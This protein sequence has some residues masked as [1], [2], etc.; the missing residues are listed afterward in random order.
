MLLIS[1]TETGEAVLTGDSVFFASLF[2]VA[3]LAG[4]IE[5]AAAA[6]VFCTADTPAGEDEAVL[7]EEETLRTVLVGDGCSI[8]AGFLFSDSTCFL[9]RLTVVSPT[10]K[11]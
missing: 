5:P 2:S 3:A 6:G 10:P 7:G 11:R 9:S 8:F 1:G 4:S